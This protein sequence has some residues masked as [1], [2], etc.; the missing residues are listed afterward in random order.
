LVASRGR[1]IGE[2][3]RAKTVWR[4]YGKP[5][6]SAQPLHRTSQTKTLTAPTQTRSRR[7]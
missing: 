6:A 4:T 3:Q 2:T 5:L 1:A 7:K